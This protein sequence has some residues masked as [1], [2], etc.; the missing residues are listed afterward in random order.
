VGG[1][2]ELEARLVGLLG[3]HRALVERLREVARR[4][5]EASKRARELAVREVE[6]GAGKEELGGFWLRATRPVFRERELPRWLALVALGS[7]ADEKVVLESITVTPACLELDVAYRRRDGGAWV[8]EEVAIPLL[9]ECRKRGSATLEEL[10]VAA[11]LLEDEDW[12]WVEEVLASGAAAWEE[13]ARRLE[14]IAAQ[15]KLLLG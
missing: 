13:A 11:A 3:R 15:L 14:S 5:A 7:E 8:V 2:A 9:G 6:L 10:L 12:E 1:V 4:G